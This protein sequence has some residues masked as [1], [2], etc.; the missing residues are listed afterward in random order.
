M[1]HALGIHSCSELLEQRALLTALFKPA[2]SNFFLQVS[3]RQLMNGT[4]LRSSIVVI[5]L[6]PLPLLHVIGTW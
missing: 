5:L 3:L 1:L 6:P 4:T 2:S